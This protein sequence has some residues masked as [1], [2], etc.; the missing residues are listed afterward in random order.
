MEA[1]SYLQ[2]KSSISRSITPRIPA[3]TD[4]AC[5]CSRCGPLLIDR[6]EP[7]P[8]AQ[9][10]RRRPSRYGQ[11]FFFLLYVSERS[12][13]WE[14]RW[15][16]TQ[17]TMQPSHVH[18]TLDE[19]LRVFSFRWGGGRVQSAFFLSCCFGSHVVGVLLVF[20]Y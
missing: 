9:P 15:V 11:T 1:A 7:R 17:G 10:T 20:F 8:V 2:A 6:K 3:S 12:I 18:I 4:A 13:G 16:R 14:S 5:M 19:T